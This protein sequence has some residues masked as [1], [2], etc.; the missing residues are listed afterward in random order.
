MSIEENNKFQY[1]IN[2]NSKN[3]NNQSNNSVKTSTII[4]SDNLEDIDVIQRKIEYITKYLKPYILKTLNEV[5]QN[6]PV[7]AKTICS[8]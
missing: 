3:D 6:N 1:Y 5:L 4:L 8:I 2:F 7:N